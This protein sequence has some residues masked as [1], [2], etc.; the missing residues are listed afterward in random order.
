MTAEQR[1]VLVKAVR[2]AARRELVAAI[3]EGTLTE[4]Q[5]ECVVELLYGVDGLAIDAA[6]E[7]LVERYA[8]LLATVTD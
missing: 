5:R 4:R 8:E 7:V 1:A 6:D 3:C 2:R